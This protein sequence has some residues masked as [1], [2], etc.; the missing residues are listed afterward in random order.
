MMAGHPSKRISTSGNRYIEVPVAWRHPSIDSRAW[1]ELSAINDHIIEHISYD[2]ERARDPD[3]SLVQA[4]RETIARGLGVCRDYAA[5]FEHLA[6]SRGFDAG[7][8]RSSRMD[9]AWNVVRLGG[10]RWIVDVTWNDGEIFADGHSIPAHVKADPDYR[11]RYFLT[12]TGREQELYRDGLI[13]STHA[14][15]DAEA[16]DYE[17]T[18]EAAALVDRI[19]PLVA[20][21]QAWVDAINAVIEQNNALVEEYNRVVHAVNSAPTTP[22][23]ERDRAR[24]ATLRGQLDSFDARIAPLRQE[25]AALDAQIDPLYGQ[26]IA[27]DRA[28]PIGIE[29]RLTRTSG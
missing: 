2:H 13:G 25:N 1:D 19:S 17:R 21:R 10:S 15:T 16:I 8:M 11:K 20:R 28:H 7:S 29:Y 5:L 3:A 23:R 9:H 12:T 4:P 18:L 14:T 6:R 27:L 22:A 24:L 26:Y